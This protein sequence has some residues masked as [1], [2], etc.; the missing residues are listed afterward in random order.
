MTEIVEYERDE[1][2]LNMLKQIAI[3]YL[4]VTHIDFI[5]KII[6]VTFPK[7]PKNVCYICLEE[8]ENTTRA[9]YVCNY[10]AHVECGKNLEKCGC[11]KQ[12]YYWGCYGISKPQIK[13]VSRNT[14][15][16]N[17]DDRFGNLLVSF[18]R[19]NEN[20]LEN[21]RNIESIIRSYL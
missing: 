20:L 5:P 11:C 2:I 17:R 6:S 10:H 21:S 4:I 14:T 1:V 12:K 8:D 9:C 15:Q 19:T 3:R 7:K 16:R 18:I 13:Q